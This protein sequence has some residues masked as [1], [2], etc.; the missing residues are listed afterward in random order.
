MIKALLSLTFSATSLVVPQLQGTSMACQWEHT[1]PG[2]DH[3]SSARAHTSEER[4][5]ALSCICS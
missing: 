4:G 5:E 3:M 2:M 1:H